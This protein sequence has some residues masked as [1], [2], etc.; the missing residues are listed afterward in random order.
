MAKTNNSKGKKW[1]PNV[2]ENMGRVRFRKKMPRDV[3]LTFG[4]KH[5]QEY[6][7]IDATATFDEAFEAAKPA[8]LR[9]DAL[10]KSL[11]NTSIDAFTENELEALAAEYLRKANLDRGDLAPHNIG[12]EFIKRHGLE[13]IEERVGRKLTSDDLMRIFFPGIS[14]PS[15]RVDE[16]KAKLG[17]SEG[18]LFSEVIKAEPTI[19]EIAQL[20]A[21]E[22]ATSFRSRQ[23]KTL[24]SYWQDYLEFNGFDDPDNRVVKR[25]QKRWDRFLAL[26]GDHIVTP[27][28]QQLIDD[29]LEDQVAERIKQVAPTTATRELKEV[30][31]A[32]NMMALKQRPKW[33]TFR[34]P[35]VPS[36]QEKER[37]PLSI[38]DQITL[39]SHC[40]SN[41]HDWVSAVHL[42]ELQGG[43]M[44][45][46][47]RTLKTDDLHLEGNYPHIIVRK[48]KT[49]ARTRVIPVVLGLSVIKTNIK[50]A[51]RCLDVKD[52]SATPRNRI[53]KLFEGRYTCHCL[54]HTIRLNGT[55]N[56]VNPLHIEA[57]CGWSSTIMN[58]QMLHY[59]NAGLAD[60]SEA[61]RQLFQAS[62]QIHQHL[63]EL[64][65]Q[66]VAAPN[67]AQIR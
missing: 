39:V 37:P 9:Y 11:R 49:T 6:L 60:S 10:V 28:T 63:L 3:E 40:L 41:G 47:I 52:P 7:P 19:Q 4:K 34:I 51:I 46:E 27:D 50:E 48:G 12:P 17:I 25:M 13:G 59:G 16:L 58:K 42:L 22:A 31:S 36:H 24:T 32:L 18:G 45:Q 67:V 33:P 1:P 29:A 44:A 15:D 64:D 8:K 30:V 61:M 14:G 2:G 26:V 5:F 43:M 66:A 55:S 35:K 62:I 54:R 38:E 23:P 20:R 57:I 56:N 65:E 21:A 53:K